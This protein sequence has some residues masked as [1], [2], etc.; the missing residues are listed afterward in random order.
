MTPRLLE[1]IGRW[2]RPRVRFEERLSG[3]YRL[4]GSRGE[5]RE[6]PLRVTL[7]ATSDPRSPLV[8]FEVQDGLVQGLGLTDA[9]LTG[10]AIT[11][12]NAKFGWVLEYVLRTSEDLWILAAKEIFAG[13][14]YAGFTTL[15]GTVLDKGRGENVAELCLRF[16]ARG[17]VGW[18]LERLR[19][20]AG[21]RTAGGRLA[22]PRG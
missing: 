5:D 14:L 18:W 10:G 11:I 21:V 8:R 22:R 12:R 2:A 6:R 3:G 17:D 20:A 9:P 15:R 19:L 7:A 1:L 4:V 13:D 16:D